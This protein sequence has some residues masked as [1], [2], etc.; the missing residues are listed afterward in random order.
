M[1]E[2]A[3]AAVLATSASWNAR[4]TSSLDG[5]LLSDDIPIIGGRV[6]ATTSQQVPD[7]LS[8]RVPRTSV[9]D[10]RTVDWLPRT[11]QSPLARYGQVLDVTIVADGVDTRIGRFLIVDWSFDET[12]ITV[13]GAGTL[14]WA[15][16]DRL[17]VAW[18]PRDGA[19][20]RSE[21]DRLL[22]P[23]MSAQFDAALVDRAVPRSMEWS[24]ER[25][26]DLYEIADAWPARIRMDQWGQV[27]VKPPLPPL[28]EPVLTF[29]DGEGGTVVSVPRSE[30]RAR[31]YNHVVARS[32]ADGVDAWAEAIQTSGPMA[33]DTYGRVT[34]FF[35]SPL[36]DSKE[37]CGAA[38][39]TILADAIR[40]T[41]VIQVEA[42]P[43]PRVELDDP[44]EIIRGYRAPKTYTPGV[45]RERNRAVNPSFEDPS[46]IPAGG[47]QSGIWSARGGSSLYVPTD[48]GGYGHG[49]YGSGE[50]GYS[51]DEE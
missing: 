9:V 48:G 4:V 40:P 38:A 36:L 26:D 30:T 24:E 25:L 14:S 49:P 37:A 41:R 46:K 32:S 22:P 51:I 3:S 21:F 39:R 50:Y 43:D 6:A 13:Q 11:P 17:P 35:S 15:V 18:S 42:A 33:V 19:T 27:L 34:K 44:V 20:L 31:S 2:G 45:P 12:E 5:V 7:V 16:E 47:A 8:M 23:Q 10:G 29:R 1:R 28:S